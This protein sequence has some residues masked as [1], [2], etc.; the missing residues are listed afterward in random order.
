MA[1]FYDTENDVFLSET[2]MSE[3]YHELR[4]CDATEAE[5][6]V[7]YIS[8]CLDWETV[9]VPKEIYDERS[10]YEETRQALCDHVANYHG[11]DIK[12]SE[13]HRHW[14]L[15]LEGEEVCK[16]RLMD[17]L[18]ALTALYMVVDATTTYEE[19]MRALNLMVNTWGL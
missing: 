1:Y 19:G 2:D 8:N 4:A 13:D 10:L 11:W 17:V 5:T 14:A 16:I 9:R 12:L 6:L 18:T 7:E 3:I 15:T